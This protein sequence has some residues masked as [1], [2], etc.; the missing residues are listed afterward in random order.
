[1]LRGWWVRECP[2]SANPRVHTDVQKRGREDAAPRGRA[3]A[4]LQ[5]LGEKKTRN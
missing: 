3:G 5:F 4:Q 1:L 2:A